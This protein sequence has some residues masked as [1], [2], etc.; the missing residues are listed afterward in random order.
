[1]LGSAIE[2]MFL[3]KRINATENRAVLHTALRNRSGNAVM[4]D[5]EDVMPEINRVLD[6]MK[7]FSE[8]LRDGSWTGYSGKRIRHI[9]N[10][11]IGGSDLGPVMVTEALRP[12]W[13][14]ITP[15]FVSNVDGTHIAETLKQVDPETTLFII[16]S[17]TF[18]TQETMTNAESARA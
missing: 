17:K 4:V 14:D 5:G 9:V 2:A 16:A 12:Y 11:G 18:T 3:G 6:Q 13:T 7:S 10:I 8:R 15:H 1:E